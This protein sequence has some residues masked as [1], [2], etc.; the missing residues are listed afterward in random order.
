M[1]RPDK[2]GTNVPEDAHS[3]EDADCSKYLCWVR[4]HVD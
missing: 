1:E 3:R 4:G 2:K